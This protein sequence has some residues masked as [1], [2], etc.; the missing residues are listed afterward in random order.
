MPQF[1]MS[2]K[3]LM[4]GS[5][6]PLANIPLGFN[7][8]PQYNKFTF[9]FSSNLAPGA[10]V[11]TGMSPLSMTGS[12]G[13]PVAKQPKPQPGL[14]AAPPMQNFAGANTRQLFLPGGGDNPSA[15]NFFNT[16]NTRTMFPPGQSASMFNPMPSQMGQLMSPMRNNTLRSSLIRR[17]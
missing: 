9:N 1:P 8:D 4:T 7:A 11:N 17:G 2:L 16:A 3:D 12:G 14:T 15:F 5:G 13:S 10:G 6:N